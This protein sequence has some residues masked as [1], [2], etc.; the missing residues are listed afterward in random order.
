MS[1]LLFA[2]CAGAVST[3][4][5]PPRYRVSTER[6]TAYYLGTDAEKVEDTCP[7]NNILTQYNCTRKQENG[8]TCFDV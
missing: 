5:K 3:Q 2:G 1:A 7:G 6:E 4:E 8:Y